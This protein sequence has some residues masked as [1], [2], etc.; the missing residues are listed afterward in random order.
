MTLPAFRL[1]LPLPSLRWGAISCRRHRAPQVVREGGAPS[2]RPLRVATLQGVGAAELRGET[3]DPEANNKRVRSP[4]SSSSSPAAATP[5]PTPLFALARFLF[6][7]SPQLVFFSFRL[8]RWPRSPGTRTPR[9]T[10][11]LGP[12]SSPTKTKAC[13]CPGSHRCRR[14][15]ALGRSA[16][17]PRS[18]DEATPDGAMGSE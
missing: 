7:L 8:E 16:W 2:P 17:S 14:T 1:C 15:L 4:P 5:S 13:P 6:Q 3:F 10:P 9:C 11:S 18:P 12:G